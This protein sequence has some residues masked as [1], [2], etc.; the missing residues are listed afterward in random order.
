M[1]LS[2]VVPAGR[3]ATEIFFGLHRYEVLQRPQYVRL[4]IGT[5]IGEKETISPREIGAL[6]KV[7]YAEPTWL[8]VGYH[9]PYYRD[10][11]YFITQFQIS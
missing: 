2:T 4:L 5:V 9:S 11:R 7:P 3:D 1:S 8:S 6:S 10:V